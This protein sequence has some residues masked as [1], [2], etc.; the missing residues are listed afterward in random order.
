MATPNHG[1]PPTCTPP[2]WRGEVLPAWWRNMKK[3]TQGD[4][5]EVVSP[6]SASRKRTTTF[7]VVRFLPFSPCIPLIDDTYHPETTYTANRKYVQPSND[8]HCLSTTCMAHRRHV[9]HRQYVR[10]P[11]DDDG[12]NNAAT[13]SMTT[14]CRPAQV[15]SRGCRGEGY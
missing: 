6:A 9:C 11:I 13:T 8:T 2:L 15:R 3:R 1:L 12:D 7:V 4:T 10:L 14:R 5:Q